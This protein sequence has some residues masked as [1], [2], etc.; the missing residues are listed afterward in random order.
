M[1]VRRA[2]ITVWN[3]VRSLKPCFFTKMPLFSHFFMILAEFR[4]PQ[5]FEFLELRNNLINFY[6]R[7]STLRD[8]LIFRGVL[9]TSYRPVPYQC[10]FFRFRNRRKIFFSCFRAAEKIS[11]TGEKFPKQEK[12]SKTWDF[13]RNRR[14]ISPE[15]VNFLWFCGNFQR[16]GWWLALSRSAKIESVC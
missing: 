9:P 7:I 16:I 6:L 3:Q 4:W 11:E 12:K 15:Q 1:D 2:Q 13:F 5:L 10:L 8:T 14:N